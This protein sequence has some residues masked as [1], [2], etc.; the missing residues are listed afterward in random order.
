MT[1][2]FRALR[3]LRAP[4]GRNGGGGPTADNTARLALAK[5]HESP[6]RELDLSV[7]T[8]LATPKVTAVSP[9]PNDRLMATTRRDAT[10]D[11]GHSR[12]FVRESIA[13]NAPRLAYYLFPKIEV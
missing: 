2:L 5:G 6:Y 1:A 10:P 12:H 4:A 9:H 3:A 11:G 13:Q 8:A 7:G